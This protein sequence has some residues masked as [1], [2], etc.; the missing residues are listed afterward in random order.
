MEGEVR[1]TLAGSMSVT[2]EMLAVCGAGLDDGDK[3][4][5]KCQNGGFSHGWPE[6]LKCPKKPM[7]I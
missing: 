6:V 2:A 3:M 7:F 1:R 5:W 4:S